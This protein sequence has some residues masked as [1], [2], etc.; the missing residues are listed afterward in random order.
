VLFV[1]LDRFKLVND[2]HGHPGGDRVLVL[3]GH[4]IASAIRAA[5][6]VGSH[7][8][9]ASDLIR[10]ADRAMYLAKEAGRDRLHFE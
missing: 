2:G 9:D 5:D 7:A 6:T 1:D 3:A 8:D 4:R 10:R